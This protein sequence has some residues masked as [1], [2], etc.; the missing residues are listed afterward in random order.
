[1]YQHEHVSS[2]DPLAGCVPCT[3]RTTR[4]CLDAPDCNARWHISGGGNNS[5]P[6]DYSIV[7]QRPESSAPGRSPSKG[8]NC[9]KYTTWGLILLA[10]VC[11]VAYCCT[12][13]Q[14]ARIGSSANTRG[15]AY[16]SLDQQPPTLAPFDCTSAASM[17]LVK[18]SYCCKSHGAFCSEAM[19][20]QSQADRFDCKQ[21]LADASTAWS[22]SKKDWCCEHRGM[23]C[24]INVP[25][26]APVATTVT[27]TS[28]TARRAPSPSSM[29]PPVPFDCDAGIETWQTTWPDQKKDWCCQNARKGCSMLSGDEYGPDES[30]YNCEVGTGNWVK[31]WPTPKKRWCC[32]QT[33]NGCIM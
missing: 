20:A 24:T 13:L 9:C 4:S 32:Q 28:T 16:N 29:Q 31:D 3:S 33:G 17:S 26:L 8:K 25:T 5:P 1:M 30:K 18:A 22:P 14:Q 11:L 27:T 15:S 21:D 23:G 7:A 6:Y 10:L 2:P 19:P 12:N